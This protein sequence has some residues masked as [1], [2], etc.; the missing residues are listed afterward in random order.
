MSCDTGFACPYSNLSAPYL[1]CDA[2]F[3]CFM[4]ATTTC[5]DGSDGTG[6]PCP[7]GRYCE[8]GT[9]SIQECPIGTFSPDERN[10]KI[11]DCQNCTTRMFCSANGL[12]EPNG[13]CS[14]GFYCPG[15][16]YRADSI[17]CPAGHFCPPRSGSPRPC[18]SGQYQ[19][20]SG[21]FDCD[22]CP[23]G[24]VCNATFEPVIFPSTPCPTGYFCPNGTE[25]GEQHPCPQGKI[26][27]RHSFIIVRVTFCILKPITLFLD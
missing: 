15:G 23:E 6:W 16:D 9:Q 10:V 18:P 17:E 12:S 25:Y 5:P 27:I 13:N 24:L 8:A 20:S 21:M 22:I 14:A 11:S 3:F 1:P 19:S 7:P 2:G 4:N 26:V